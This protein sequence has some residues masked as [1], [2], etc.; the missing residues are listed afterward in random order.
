[1]RVFE[2]NGPMIHAKAAVADGRWARVGSTNLNVASWIG[3]REL[4]VVVEDEAFARAMQEQYPPGPGGRYRDRPGPA[5]PGR[6]RRP[7]SR[8]S[9]SPRSPPSGRRRSR[10][11]SG[12]YAVARP[13]V[14]ARAAR[15]SGPRA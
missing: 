3:N 13:R 1:M 2:W 6:T 15:D 14:L 10:G 8:S 7:A 5:P 11:R 4:D 9:P 12:P